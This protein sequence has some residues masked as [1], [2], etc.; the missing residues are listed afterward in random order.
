MKIESLGTH[1]IAAAKLVQPIIDL[2]DIDTVPVAARARAVIT[3]REFLEGRRRIAD[4]LAGVKERSPYVYERAGFSVEHQERLCAAIDA[5]IEVIDAG[6]A[7]TAEVAE[8]CCGVGI[9][10]VAMRDAEGYG[11][12]DGCKKPVKLT[13]KQRV[14]LDAARRNTP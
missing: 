14:A 10:V 2:V 12:C 6:G 9:T 5:L 1:D 11:Q 8:G 4:D 13:A 7:C 3:L